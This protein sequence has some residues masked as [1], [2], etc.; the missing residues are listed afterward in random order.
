MLP[1]KS[2]HISINDV[3]PKL[4]QDF[5]GLAIVAQVRWAHVDGKFAKD[6]DEFIL[7]LGHFQLDAGLV[8]TCQVRMAEAKL[9]STWT[10]TWDF[11]QRRTCER[12]LDD[13]LQPFE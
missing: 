3:V 8:E 10:S 2:I 9:L 1:I 13:P 11:K 7:Q 6:F 5:Q 12:L 4:A